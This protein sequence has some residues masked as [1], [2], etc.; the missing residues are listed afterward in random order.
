MTQYALDQAHN[1]VVATWPCGTGAV[2]E[3]ATELPQQLSAEQGLRL[4]DALSGLSRHLWRTYTRPASAVDSLELNSEGWQ[5]E[6][7]RQAFDGVI[8]ALRKPN[9]PDANGMML[10]SYSPAGE[11]AHRLG[12]VLHEIADKGVVDR[13]VADVEA[14][15]AA[16]ELAE[17]G[18]LSGRARQAVELTRAD[19]SPVQVAAANALL[20][21]EPLG[22]PRLFNEIDPTAAS[23][24]AAHWLQAA[25]DV[26]AEVADTGPTMVIAEADDIEAIAVRTPSLVLELLNAGAEP[27]EVVTG[28]IGDAM[29]VAEGRIPNVAGLLQQIVDAEQ[30]ARDYGDRA[31]EVRDVL[32][33]DRVTPL[34]PSRPAQ[35]LLEDLLDGIR[36]CWLLYHEYAEVTGDGELGD[37][38]DD[39]EFERRDAELDD[40]FTDAVRTEATAHHDRLL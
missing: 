37:D 29:D 27:R 21:E 6:Q 10:Q 19:A 1:T 23:V 8:P 9:L 17:R 36:G 14:E 13:I 33:P 20:H 15:L 5:R 34:D 38:A 40:A 24:A 28:L 3:T 32:M 35:D 31:D 18:E 7:E 39:A 25:A 2:A 30:Q 11:S 12:R 16:I 4:A 26:V 22:S